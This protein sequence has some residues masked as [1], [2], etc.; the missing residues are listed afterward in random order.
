LADFN[1]NIVFFNI[2][3]RI[4][5]GEN[6]LHMA[7]VNEDPSMVKFFLD[8]GVDCS[9]RC[10]GNFFTPED[11][12]MTRRDNMNS[13]RINL[14]QK[15]NYNGYVYFGEFAHCF[16]ACLGQEECYRLILSKGVNAD[17]VDVNG[18]NIL[19]ILVIKGKMVSLGSNEYLQNCGLKVQNSKSRIQN[20]E[21]KIKNLKSKI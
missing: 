20:Q 21:F 8:Q 3:K 13:E 10:D 1:Q 18:N 16:A 14:I 7:V 5:L 6:V 17:E 19:H 9:Q 15:T 12:K 2:L 4:F 11:Q